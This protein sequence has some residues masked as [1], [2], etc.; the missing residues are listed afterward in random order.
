MVSS[1]FL[2]DEL[3]LTHSPPLVKGMLEKDTSVFA[4]KGK[5]K[6]LPHRRKP[7]LDMR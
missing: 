2:V 6:G 4:G 3:I 7:C 1:R 5:R